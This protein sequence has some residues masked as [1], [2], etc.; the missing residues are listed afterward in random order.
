MMWSDSLEGWVP[1][2]IDR[3]SATPEVDWCHL[4]ARRFTDPFFNQTI[5]RRL[6]DPFALLFRQR[7]PLD[8]LADRAIDHPGL[9]PAGFIFHMSRCGSTLIAQML[10]ALPQ[11]VVISE[12]DPIDAVLRIPTAD[13]GLRIAW[14][15][16]MIAAMGQPRDG[17]ETALVVKF[18]SWNTLDLPLIRRAFPTVPWVF[19]YRNPVEVLVS[20]IKQRAAYMLPGQVGPGSSSSID[21]EAV[22]A[23]VTRP[24]QH[25]GKVLSSFCQAALDQHHHDPGL[26]LNYSELPEAVGARLL[27]AFGLGSTVEDIER[28]QITTQCHA[29]N[30]PLPFENDTEAKN[31]EATPLIRE[32]ADRYL[33]SVY[34]DLEASRR[35]MTTDPDLR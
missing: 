18:D 31:R 32:M 28:M 3:K 19:V 20:Q 23:S 22:V 35:R 26:L 34:A 4:G 2:R 8:L 7:T 29:K 6:R 33:G 27:E 24:E 13:D 17:G 14:F 1:I 9:P 25:C 10:A 12:A 30:P 16:G 5:E 15:R 11:T 21:L